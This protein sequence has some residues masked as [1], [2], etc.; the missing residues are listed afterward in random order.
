MLKTGEIGEIAVRGPQLMMG[1]WDRP[2]ATAE[3]LIDGWL[4]TGDVGRLDNDGYLFLHDRMKD[5]IVNMG[6]NVYPAM[7]ENVLH[8][9]PAVAAAAV[10]G[11][12]DP[13]TGEAVK[14]VVV[15]REKGQ[16]DEQEL[17][18]FCESDLG[19]HQRPVSVDF[20]E[21]LPCNAMGKVLKRILR[22]PYWEGRDRRIGGV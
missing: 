15:L 11:V 6:R 18:R 16:A 1:Y 13:E 21:S 5:V 12:P 9:H 8:N 3:V 20:V 4:H 19:E 7:V 22:E 14:A 2:E 10:I 17:L